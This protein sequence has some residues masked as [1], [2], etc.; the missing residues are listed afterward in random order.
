MRLGKITLSPLSSLKRFRP[1]AVSSFAAH[2]RRLSR[3]WNP[4]PIPPSSLPFIMT[5]KKKPKP[6]SSGRAPSSSPSSSTQ[7]SSDNKQHAPRSPASS[8]PVKCD[9]EAADNAGSDTNPILDLQQKL[10][11][12]VHIEETY[13]I[14]T[15][16]KDLVVIPSIQSELPTLVENP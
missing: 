14:A 16:P 2:L 8:S 12:T 5:R 11:A 10:D 4:A 3:R 7:F 1:L 13:A 6:S 15:P 9:L